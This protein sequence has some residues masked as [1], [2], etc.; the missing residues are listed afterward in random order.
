MI[1]FLSIILT[2]WFLLRWLNWSLYQSLPLA[3]CLVTVF[4]AVT[5]PALSVF[6]LVTPSVVRL[7]A[8]GVLFYFVKTVSPRELLEKLRGYVSTLI[9]KF[10]EQKIGYKL[11]YGSFAALV[12]MILGNA[13]LFPP[14]NWDSM[15]YHMTRVA[16]WVQNQSV[17]PYPTA[18]PRQ[19]QMTPGA[20]YLIL[21]EQLFW[22][23]DRF[24]NMI[25]ANAFIVISVGM[26]SWIRTWGASA[27]LA[28][29]VASFFAAAPMIVLQAQTTQNDLVAA[30]SAVTLGVFFIDR[31][32]EKSV[33]SVDLSWLIVAGIWSVILGAA[34][35]VKPTSLLVVAPFVGTALLFEVVSPKLSIL[36]KLRVVSVVAII[37]ALVCGP[38]VLMKTRSGSSMSRPEVTIGLTR[39]VEQLFNGF[40]HIVDHVDQT[41]SVPL[42]NRVAEWLN[43]KAEILT[44]VSYIYFPNEDLAGNPLQFV[45]AICFIGFTAW[46]RNWFLLRLG[47]L[48]GCSWFLLHGIVNNQT[49][50]SRLQTPWFCLLIPIL[51]YSVVKLTMDNRVLRVLVTLALT[52][53]L[54]VQSW[55]TLSRLKTAGWTVP[56]SSRARYDAY[57]HRRIGARYGWDRLSVKLRECKNISLYSGL[58]DFDYPVVWPTVLK[59]IKVEYK[60]DDKGANEGCN[61]DPRL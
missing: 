12:L 51:G 9:S 58:D 37:F 15:T 38:E 48:L 8:A 31:Y 57:Y 39:P 45:F 43:I 5:L 33:R 23:S 54:V 60:L 36:N 14:S 30:V 2:G 25:Q 61:L 24:A 11:F 18:N 20:E 47:L 13:V 50:M 52:Q 10:E 6:H 59:G 53:A 28:S 29:L 56:L 55:V 27:Q 40:R 1:I 44:N 26:I 42:V 22:M 46:K 16:F 32:V 41:I 21:V 3:F 7:L 35:I 4:F 49:W 19:F 17:F 34:Y